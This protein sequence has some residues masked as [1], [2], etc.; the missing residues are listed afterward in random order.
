[1][2]NQIGI[3]DLETRKDFKKAHFKHRMSA[4]V[5]L[6]SVLEQSP[7]D[8][9]LDF[10]DDGPE[11]KVHK[12]FLRVSSSVFNHALANQTNP[13]MKAREGG[14]LGRGDK[15]STETQNIALSHFPSSKG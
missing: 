10:G 4:S 6:A 1:M 8:L 9:V 3:R 5:S 15:A 13:S 2:R 11:T 12:T 7:G 14:R